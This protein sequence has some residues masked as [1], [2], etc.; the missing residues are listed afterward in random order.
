MS[1]QTSFKG[2]YLIQRIINKDNGEPIFYIGQSNNLFKRLEAHC[3][4][5]GIQEIDLA[6]QKYGIES[7]SFTI[8]KIENKQ[9]QRDILEKQ[10]I[11]EFIN[12]YGN[13]KIYDR[14]NGGKNKQ[15][16][17]NQDRTIINKNDQI[18]I[19]N[20]LDKNIDYSI[21][22]LAERFNLNY[23]LVI[24]IRKPLLKK[25]NLHYNY[26]KKAIVDINTNEKP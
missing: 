6:I 15:Q 16:L 7:F 19:I 18:E 26:F 13:D 11:S 23:Q 25:H 24:N 9:K 20:L 12:K 4:Y 22:L 5:S 14:S 21:Y 2:L 10:F 8:L 3:N 1:K 17:I